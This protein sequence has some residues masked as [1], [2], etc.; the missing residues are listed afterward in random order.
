MKRSVPS[1]SRSG[2][3]GQEVAGVLRQILPCHNVS[4]TQLEKGAE[5]IVAFPGTPQPF[6]TKEGH[7][8]K[9]TYDRTTGV[10][11]LEGSQ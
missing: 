5:G 11:L 3:D 9:P 6:L 4:R 8:S 1:K 10:V 2:F 7:S